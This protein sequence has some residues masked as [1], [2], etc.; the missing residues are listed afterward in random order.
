MQ[1][2]STGGFMRKLYSFK[3]SPNPIFLNYSRGTKGSIHICIDINKILKIRQNNTGEQR[4][5]R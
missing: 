4:I 5:K 2:L 3:I 1:K